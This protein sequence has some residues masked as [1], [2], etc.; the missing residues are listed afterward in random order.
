MYMFLRLLV[1]MKVSCGWSFVVPRAKN[2]AYSFMRNM[3]GSPGS[4][5]AMQR[6]LFELYTHE[7]AMIPIL[8]SCG[9]MK[10]PFVYTHC[11][12]LYLGVFAWQNM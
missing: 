8:Y 10:E 1:N 12:G 6:P 3:L 9:S 4:H 11:C 2:K 7:S 5:F